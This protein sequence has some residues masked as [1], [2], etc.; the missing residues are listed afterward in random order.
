[1]EK[2]KILQKRHGVVKRVFSLI[3]AFAMVITMT[4]FAPG[5]VTAKA[6]DGTVRLYLELPDGTSAGDWAANCWGG[7]ALSGGSDVRVGGTWNDQMKPSLI[8]GDSGWGYVDVSGKVEGFQFVKWIKDASDTTTAPTAYSCWNAQIAAQGLTEAYFDPASQKWYKEASKTTEIKE[9]EVRNIFVLA[10]AEELTGES[11]NKDSTKNRLVQDA[12]DSNK[13]S[14]TY[15]NVA[16]GTYEYKILQDP[17]NKGWDLPWGP[18]GNNRSVTVTAPS[19]VTFTIDVTD[20]SKSVDVSVEGI[21]SLVVENGNIVKGKETELNTT[22]QYYD[23]VSATPQEVTV[24]YALKGTQAGVTLNGNKVTVAETSTLTEV[25]LTVTYDT[26]SQDITIPVVSK[27]YNV[28]IYMY[29]PDLEMRPGV[30]DIYI[31]EVGGSRNTVVSLTETYEDTDNNVTWVKGTIKLPYNTL[32]IIARDVADSWG[33]GQD[34]DRSYTIDEDVTEVTLWYEY[35]KNPTTVKPTIVATEQRYLYMLYENHTIDFTPKFSS[36][37]TGY[38]QTS[39]SFTPIGDGLWEIWVPVKASCTKV[40]YVLVYDDSAD[41]W[42]KDGGDHSIEFPADQTIV[43]ASMKEGGEPTLGA[44]YNSGYELQPKDGKVSFYYRDD[45]ALKAGTLAGMTVSVDVDGTEHP[46][47]YNAANKR[48]EYT[49]DLK[50]GR[51]H[52]R[53]KVGSE[54]VLDKFNTNSEAVDATDYSYVEYE[55]LEANIVAEV[56]NPSFNY[57]ENNVVKFTVSQEEGQTELEVARA[58]ID[59]SSLGG[60]SALAIEPE[61]CAVSISATVNTTLG[62][63]TLPIVVTDQY[64][65]E[66]TTSVDVEVTA[67]TKA[68]EKDFDW[69]E[70]VIYFMVTDRFFDGNTANNT[71]SGAGTYGDNEGLY[72][73]GDFAGVTAK[74][75]YLADLGIN[76][77]W[78]TPIVENIPGV[79]VTGTG[80]ADVPYNAAYHGYWA[81]DFTKLNP[82]LGTEAEFET[83]IAEAHKRGI[84]I[85]VDIVVNHAGYDT[86]TGQANYNSDFDGMFR[87]G[88][89]IIAGDDQK[90]EQ[91]GMPDFKTEDPSVRA[92]LV[93]WQTQWVKDYGVDYFRVDTVKHVEGTTWAAL[94]NALTEIDPSFKMIGEYYGA[95]Y[96]A[97]GGT[98]GS[99]QMDSD[100][101]FDFNDQATNLVSGNISAVESFMAARNAALNNTYMT[102]HFL[103]S[104]DETG[105]KQNLINGKGMTTEAATAAALVAATLQITAKGQPVIYYGE[106]IGLTG[107]NNY[108]Y[109]TNR[110]DFDWTL[111]NENNVTYQHYKKMLAI[112]N[113]YAEVFARGNRTT[114]DA[115]DV[116]GYD[117]MSRSYGGVTLYVGMNIK[118]AAKEV[119]IPVNAAAG[120][121]YTNLYDGK[122]YTA[123]ADGKVTVTIPAAKDGGTVV[124]VAEKAQDV[125]PEAPVVPVD[126]EK[127]TQSGWYDGWAGVSAEQ[128]AKL[129][130]ESLAQ[131]AAVTAPKTDDNAPIAMVIGVMMAGAVV[132]IGAVGKKRKSG[133]KS[134]V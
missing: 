72:H 113:A 92:K 5:G 106:E 13:Y 109:Q 22:A 129:M 81:S 123:A 7:A 126:P 78:I 46:M 15:N 57:N 98:L 79:T 112:R 131:N 21:K 11:W 60:S 114:I 121:V 84:R 132:V 107:E 91:S 54:Y 124:L 45:S 24:T 118:D 90:S 100:L 125:V 62:T 75:D 70:A 67:R 99:G 53:Y 66:Y 30:S 8:A 108:P 33:G 83:M 19:N 115:N 88:E 69:D 18:D 71:A 47:V 58:T 110:Y 50:N 119:A 27:E 34:G 12:T 63:K 103:G 49:G 86:K 3:L 55:K 102:G 10:G 6:D 40:D 35:G 59:V 38:A 44:P 85:M 68:N 42:V 105:F 134:L 37:T 65:N 120:S 117:I 28:T 74:L 23:G 101:D 25:A 77:I 116:A 2:K 130:R 51:T 97:N 32:G 93:E 76:T 48:F 96:A 26:F 39:L 9:A 111:A 36:W 31:F 17:E 14:I 89:D 1:M 4:Q 95:G 94:K 122:Q 56:M 61:L 80:S 73:G 20:T 29:S 128:K 41:P 133:K 104:H 82:T 87:S 64:G 52:Y 127:P 43:C 16:A